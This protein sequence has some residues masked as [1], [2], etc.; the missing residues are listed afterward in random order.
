MLKNLIA[1]FGLSEILKCLQ[2]SKRN[3][4][5]KR[6][7]WQLIF[8]HGFTYDTTATSEKG[9]LTPITQIAFSIPGFPSVWSHEKAA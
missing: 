1:Q 7:L 6:K 4:Q 3:F 9:L 2:S 5:Q 8:C